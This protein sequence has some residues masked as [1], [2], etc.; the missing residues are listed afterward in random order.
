[1]DR[2]E[3]LG[4]LAVSGTLLAASGTLPAAPKAWFGISHGLADR[5]VVIADPHLGAR[6]RA[7]LPGAEY[8]ELAAHTLLD[9]KWHSQ[10][11]R[12]RVLGAVGAANAVLL[13]E[14]LR[15]RRAA[16][17]Y[18]GRDAGAAAACA[19]LPP[20]AFTAG[21]GAGAGV[22]FI[23]ALLSQPGGG[24]SSCGGPQS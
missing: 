20:S 3:F 8:L 23:I 2:R 24:P 13:L 12:T 16:V 9:L 19:G 18:A 21:A 4:E 11:R 6:L 5:W 14:S 7:L 17:S 1:M 22:E 15:D 10:L